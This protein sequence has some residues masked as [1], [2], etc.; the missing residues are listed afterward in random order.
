M[1][2]G[3]NSITFPLRNIFFRKQSLNVHVCGMT[4]AKNYRIVEADDM[5]N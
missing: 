5:S 4:F 3:G 2:A 1:R